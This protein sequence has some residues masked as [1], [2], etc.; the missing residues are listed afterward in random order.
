MC[1]F[2]CECA[3]VLCKTLRGKDEAIV[4]SRHWAYA[5][6]VM[7]QNPCFNNLYLIVI[8]RH[9]AYECTVMNQNPC[10]NNLYLIVISRH[11]AYECTVMNQKPCFN[12][13]YHPG[14]RGTYLTGHVLGKGISVVSLGLSA[15]TSLTSLSV[16]GNRLTAVPLHIGCLRLLSRINFDNNLICEWVDNVDYPVSGMVH[17]IYPFTAPQHQP[18][19]S[20]NLPLHLHVSISTSI[21]IYIYPPPPLSVSLPP[22]LFLPKCKPTSFASPFTNN[23]FTNTK[24]HNPKP[25]T[26]RA[27][28]EHPFHLS[29]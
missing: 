10:F 6:T 11:W 13:L 28:L 19:P 17:D 21:Y 18:Q 5:C 23:R 3:C 2:V 16:S 4:I 8:S 24:P 15:F 14:G 12:N 27:N 7:N 29:K 1:V 22:S 9:W 25:L 26:L 20:S